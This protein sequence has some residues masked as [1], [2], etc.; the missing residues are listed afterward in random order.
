MR[1]KIINLLHTSKYPGTNRKKTRNSRR[2]L[3]RE[4]RPGVFACLVNRSLMHLGELAVE[5]DA[6][7]VFGAGRD[8]QRDSARAQAKGV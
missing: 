1:P 3:G 7:D 6:E 8:D 2:E 4:A 5:W